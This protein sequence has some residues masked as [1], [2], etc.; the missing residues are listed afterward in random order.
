VYKRQHILISIGFRQPFVSCLFI[1]LIHII[2]LTGVH[3][4]QEHK[5]Y[6]SLRVHEIHDHYIY[7]IG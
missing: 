3:E 1:I 2:I 7:L 6:K 5:R 4:I